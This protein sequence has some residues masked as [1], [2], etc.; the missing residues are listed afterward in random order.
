[1]YYILYIDRLFFLNLCMNLFALSLTKVFLGQRTTR[2]RIVLSAG[3]GAAGCIA[4][5]FIP[6][7]PY[8]VKTLAGFLGIGIVMIWILYPKGN[9][10]FFIKALTSLY[11]FS[12]LLGGVLLFLKKYIKPDGGNFILT[13]LFPSMVVYVSLCF[14]LKCR[15]KL[16]NECEVLLFFEEKQVKVKAFVDSGNMLTEPISKKPV[17]VMEGE[18][19]KRA[20]IRMPDEKCKVIPYH[21]VGKQNGILMGYEFPKMMIHKQNT[22]MELKK[23]IVAISEDTLFA[24]GKYQMLLHPGLLEKQ[25]FCKRKGILTDKKD[26]EEFT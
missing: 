24:N 14:F 12:F 20:G 10:A 6:G 16:Q 8:I 11:G 19:L 17:S 23:V 9:V 22:D 26:L 1:M 15:R 4:V 18:V 7:L 25:E 21:S 2:L 13:M 5:L 3:I